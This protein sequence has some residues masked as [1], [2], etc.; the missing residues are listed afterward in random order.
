MSMV[1]FCKV[2][3]VSVASLNVELPGS[4]QYHLV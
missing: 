3:R 4:G 1:K 2:M